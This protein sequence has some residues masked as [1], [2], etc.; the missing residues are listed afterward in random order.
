MNTSNPQSAFLGNPTLFTSAP[1]IDYAETDLGYVGSQNKFLLKIPN[2]Q[3]TIDAKRGQVFMIANATQAIDISGF[4][5]GLNRFF[6]DHLAFEIL[7]YFPTANTDNHFNGLGLHGVYDSK[8]ERIIITKLDYIPQPNKQVYYDEALQKFYVNQPIAGNT[9]VK[10]Y[11]NLTDVEYFCNKS[12]TASFNLNT[13]AWVS[14]HTYIPNFYIGENNFYYSG[15]N[16]GC[17][18]TAIA[19]IEIPSPTTTSTT[20]AV[21]LQCALNGEAIY[22]DT[23]AHWEN[24]GVPYCGEGSCVTYQNQIDTNPNSLTF[25]DIQY[26]EVLPNICNTA[27]NYVAYGSAYCVE[28]NAYQDYIDNNPCSSTV[29]NIETNLLGSGAPCDYEP[30]W[31]NTG[32]PYC[33]VTDPVTRT[34]TSFQLQTNTNPCYTNV[35]Q[36]RIIVS[37][38]DVCNTQPIWVQ[39]P[40]N[41]NYTCVYNDATGLYD[42]HY[43]ERDENPCSNSYTQTQTGGLV[44]GGEGNVKCNEFPNR[45]YRLRECYTQ[46]L[47]WSSAYSTQAPNQ[48]TEGDLVAGFVPP[49]PPTPGRNTTFIVIGIVIIDPGSSP[50]IGIERL[51]ATECFSTTTTTTTKH[52][53]AFARN[54]QIS[55]A[56]DLCNLGFPNTGVGGSP[57]YLS[58][59]VQYAPLVP[60]ETN[61]L[62]NATTGN[63]VSGGNKTWYLASGFNLKYHYSV[64]IDIDGGIGN[65]VQ[66]SGAAYQAYTVTLVGRSTAIDACAYPIDV[67]NQTLYADYDQTDG[68]TVPRFY[69]DELCSLKFVGN[70]FWYAWQ[71]GAGTKYSGQIS[72]LGA[73]SN[74][75]AC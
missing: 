1:A 3:I 50:A 30:A 72:N 39:L 19:V 10:R 24:V 7:R 74:I 33:E 8:F 13:K 41:V 37:P 15:L 70:D 40:E 64:F 20:T 65:W 69:T 31:V 52:V 56:V 63:P 22:S 51:G 60:F 44:P 58:G 35:E 34:C 73:T 42:E 25:G 32:D 71:L 12:W 66:C 17:D 11:V 38:I 57:A 48:P 4:G 21:P 75:T 27:A 43:I 16:E 14:F 67:S 47:F 53:Y 6:T 46:E 5:S 62:V 55:P 61:N 29:G 54:T 26:I 9:S 36:T 18:L 49:N 59:A 45:W 23:D 2:G 28:C 68:S